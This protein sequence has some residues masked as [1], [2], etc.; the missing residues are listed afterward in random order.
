MRE[1]MEETFSRNKNVDA[2]DHVDRVLNIVS[3]FNIPGVSQDSVLLRVFL[4][5]L[6]RTAKR[7][8]DRLT[9]R[10]VNTW[11]LLKK[12]FI[13]S[14]MNRQLLDSQ[15]PI[16][17]MTP[18]QALTA[19]QTMADHTQKWHDR[20]L[21]RSL[22]S[23]SNTD[24]LAVIIS[25]LDNLGRDMKKLKENV[26]AIQVGCKICEGPHLDKECPFNEEVKQVE[27]AKYGEFGCPAPFNGN[28]EAKYRVGPSGYYTR[29]DNQTPSGEKRPNVIKKINKYME[30]AAKRQAEQ[31]EWLK[32]LYQNTE[33][34]RIDHD[35]VIR[36]LESQVKTLTSEVETKA[37]II[38]GC[39]VIFATDMTPLY[40]PFYHS[41]E[42]IEYFSS[43]SEFSDDEKYENTKVKTSKVIPELTSNLPEQTEC[44]KYGHLVTPLEKNVTGAAYAIMKINVTGKVKTMATEW[45]SL[46][47]IFGNEYDN[48]DEFED[49]DGCGQCRENENFE[50]I[51]NK[52][53]DEWFKG[54][55]EDEEDLEG[56]IDYLE[57]TLYDGFI[58]SDDE[59]YKE[60]KFQQLGDNS[61]D[62]LEE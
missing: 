10:V 46:E 52:L 42:E 54:T 45:R 2:H 29:A 43:N 59:E 11:D 20:T 41:P 50:T 13:Q 4:L 48:S 3:L 12:A 53:H 62:R 33:N 35:K 19:I 15:G 44:K 8:V 27:E 47:K 49:P 60:K 22:S 14:T 26:H 55:Y 38:E 17:G 18:T 25:K 37:T 57:P 30:E 58:D 56:I 40:T 1:L 24:G 32:T 9:L 21:S 7:W 31:D 61:Q 6:T 34:N 51:I 23:S 16:P 28:N 36:K 39:K 5:T